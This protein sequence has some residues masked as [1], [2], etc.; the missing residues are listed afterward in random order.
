MLHECYRQMKR[1]LLHVGQKQA[2]DNLAASPTPAPRSSS[3]RQMTDSLETSQGYDADSREQTN[4]NQL[5]VHVHFDHRKLGAEVELP[6]QIVHR[7]TTGN[8]QTVYKPC[9]TR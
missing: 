2:T 9:H 4:H 7:Q 5:E 3:D 1:P 8:T 6:L